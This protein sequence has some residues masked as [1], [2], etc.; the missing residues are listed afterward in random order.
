MTR[1]CQWK[2]L[3]RHTTGNQ[4]CKLLEGFQGEVLGPE[5]GPGSG[6]LTDN[7]EA[8]AEEAQT[9]PAAEKEA[10]SKQT[11]GGGVPG[12]PSEAHSNSS[13]PWREHSRNAGQTKTKTYQ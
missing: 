4:S 2:S 3:D 9:A 12:H 11:H 8:G 5:A 1:E 7:G 10:P 6:V 13:T